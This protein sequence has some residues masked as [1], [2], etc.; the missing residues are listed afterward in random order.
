MNGIHQKSLFF[1]AS[2][3]SGKDEGMLLCFPIQV[4]VCVLGFTKEDVS[5]YKGEK[6]TETSLFFSRKTSM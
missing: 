6:N 2:L 1:P 5:L 3:G 4:Y